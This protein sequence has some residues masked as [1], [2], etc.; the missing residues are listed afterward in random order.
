MAPNPTALILE[1]DEMNRRVF[2]EILRRGGYEVVEAATPEEALRRGA[3]PG[4][5]LLVT[6][7]V[8]RSGSGMSVATALL[9]QQPRLKVIL[10]SASS[11]DWWPEPDRDALRELPAQSY[12]FLPKPGCVLKMLVAADRLTQRQRTASEARG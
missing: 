9:K 7:I 10:T 5:R 11:V 4:I 6:G 12:I 2:A 3:D 8:L 1:D